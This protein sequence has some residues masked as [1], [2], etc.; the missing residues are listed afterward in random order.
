MPLR[1]PLLR[2]L[3]LL[4]ALTATAGCATVPLSTVFPTAVDAPTLPETTRRRALQAHACA[5]S[6][7]DV[8]SDVLTVIDFDLPSTRERLWILD[9]STGEVRHQGLVAHGKG[10]GDNTVRSLSNVSGSHQSSL[11]VY[12]TAEVYRGKHGRSLR[13]DGLEA[14]YNDHARQRAIVLHGADY[15]SRDFIRKHGRLG[16]SHGCPAVPQADVGP[17]IDAIRDGSLLVVH[18][19]EKGW[20]AGSAYL[21]CDKSQ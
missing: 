16:R 20:L 15:V 3:V 21:H 14:G 6:R 19:S 17:V 1:R 18:R 12:R 7:G 9:A 8:R 13:L 10:S 5:T 11:G 4:V 2:P